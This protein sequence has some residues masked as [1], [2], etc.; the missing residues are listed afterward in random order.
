MSLVERKKKREGERE[1]RKRKEKGG[2]GKKR[3]RKVV[4]NNVAL[5]SLIHIPTLIYHFSTTILML[6]N[7]ELKKRLLDMLE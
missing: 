2:K 3:R 7:E 5:H 1:E 6:S 4:K